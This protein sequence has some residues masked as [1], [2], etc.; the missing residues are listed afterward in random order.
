MRTFKLHLS[1][2]L[3]SLY[4][5]FRRCAYKYSAVHV[6]TTCLCVSQETWYFQLI[7]LTAH[8]CWHIGRIITNLKRSKAQLD[9]QWSLGIWRRWNGT[10]SSSANDT[11]VGF[12]EGLICCQHWTDL[13][14]M[15]IG[16]FSALL[17]YLYTFQAFSA[18][19]T[20][21]CVL[22]DIFTLH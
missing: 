5:V 6:H 8:S 18:H 20:V 10:G 2:W 12:I 3:K 21:I 13:I 17:F 22:Y 9:A 15:K 1:R 19:A 11:E 7:K 4:S 16:I 14:R